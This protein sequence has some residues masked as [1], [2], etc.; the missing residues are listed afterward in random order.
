MVEM[1]VG[2]DDYVDGGEV[3][4]F[5]GGGSVSLGSEP[6]N[7]GCAVTPHGIGQNIQAADLEE[8]G[9]MTDPGDGESIRIIAEEGTI[10]GDE[11]EL[12]AVRMLRFAGFTPFTFPFDEIAEA[13]FTVRRPGVA[14]AVI[15]MVGGSLLVLSAGHR[16][17]L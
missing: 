12:E 14:E 10:I 2:D 7:R 5:Q 6:L 9:R 15:G 16:R 13:V 1:V 8:D 17:N 11:F 4:D 3:I